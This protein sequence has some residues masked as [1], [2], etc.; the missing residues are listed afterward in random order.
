MI[1]TLNALSRVDTAANKT[2]TPDLDHIFFTESDT[3]LVFVAVAGEWRLI[4]GSTGTARTITSTD[5][6]AATDY[7]ILADATSGA[8]TVNLL[9]AVGRNGKVYAVKKID[10][11][12]NAVTVDTAGTETIDGA[13]T[14][15]L[16]TQYA[17][18]MLVSNNANWFVI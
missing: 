7:V 13:A 6:A 8:I 16:S 2:A 9:T 1:Q 14:K 17:S 15:V 18:T 4:N 5:T 12:A 11:S 10:A 3:G